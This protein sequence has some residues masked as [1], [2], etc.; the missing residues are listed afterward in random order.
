M[1]LVSPVDGM[2]QYGKYVAMD[3]FGRVFLNAQTV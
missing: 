3:E 1:S 2:S